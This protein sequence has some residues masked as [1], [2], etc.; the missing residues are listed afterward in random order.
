MPNRILK[1]DPPIL[2]KAL[3]AVT[4]GC[5][6]VALF[7]FVRWNFA[8]AVASRV[9]VRQ[10][11]SRLVIDGLVELG[12][13]DPQTHYAAAAIFE[14]T[15]DSG[16]LERSLKEYEAA[17]A[18]APNNYQMWINLGRA[19]SLNGE[20]AGAEAAYR[21]ALELAP[22]YAAVQWALGNFLIRQ[23]RVDEGFSLA[24]KAAAGNTDY[25]R[26]AVTLALQIFEGNVA[27]V[28]RV[29]GS[30][31]TVG[32]ALVSSLA[33]QER[34]DEAVESW[35]KISETARAGTEMRQ[36]A[37][38]LVETL[39]AAKKFRLALR[40]RNDLVPE[41]ERA[42][43]GQFTNGGFEEP[44]KLRGSGPFE[45]RI[46]PGSEPQIGQSETQKRGG[47]YGLFLMF[48]SFEASQFRSFSQTI[49]VEPGAA[50]QLEGFY[51]SDLKT[52]ASIKIEVADAV[53]GSPLAATSP[54][55]LAGDWTT[56]RLDLKIPQASDGITVRLIRENCPG[57]ACRVA[58][59]MS[60]D[61]L[62]LK[63]F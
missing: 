63:Q 15:F 33:A 17:A 25:A 19:R 38:K 42:M 34:Y 49:A 10:P 8:N 20:D 57:T 60:F 9:D 28:Q 7:F 31:D 27:D 59:R 61:D 30:G 50:Y 45:W 62:T 29:L 5:T 52:T 18:L 58:G 16:D 41:A 26:S 53:S 21:K 37:E 35:S 44:I 47:R 43:V 11:E 36:L 23:G 56:I 22:N 2:G 3:V 48:N 6:L 24:A 40:V 32:A 46:D 51:R 12:P 54:L 4:L 39:L 13:S 1:L 55:A 14:K